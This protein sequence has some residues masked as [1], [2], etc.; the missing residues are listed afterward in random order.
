MGTPTQVVTAFLAEWA[1][2]EEA[3]YQSLRD[4]FSADA[5]WEN[6]GV[7]TTKGP[8]EGVAFLQGFFKD[9]SVGKMLVDMIHI[10]AAGN[11]VLTERV[12]RLIDSDGKELFGI[13]IMGVFE[14][15]DNKITAWRDYFDTASL[16]AG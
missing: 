15:R 7:A 8:E 14:V 2:S 12:D 10:A 4:Y 11:A 3:L 5:I 1:K 9:F 16:A 6:V 13:R